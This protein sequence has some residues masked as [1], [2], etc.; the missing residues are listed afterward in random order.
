MDIILT[1][2]EAN[3]NTYTQ[4]LQEASMNYCMFENDKVVVNVQKIEL[5]AKDVY[6]VGHPI[7]DK[8]QVNTILNSLQIM[9][10]RLACSGQEVTTNKL[11]A[12][13]ENM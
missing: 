11:P 9:G 1:K 3:T 6:I 10:Q 12:L 7:P 8:M 13:L 5:L 2:Y 4:L